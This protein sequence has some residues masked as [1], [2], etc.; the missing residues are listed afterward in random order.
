M[1][2]TQLIY[3]SRHR[4]LDGRSAL[5]TLRA[6]LAASQ[7]NNKRDELTGFLLFDQGWFYQILEGDHDQVISTYNRI[8]KDP[9]HENIR[10]MDR[11][12]L[13]RR[14]FPQWSMGGALRGPE[15][16][17]IFLRHGIADGIDPGK[18]AGATILA[19]ALDLQDYE[20][21]RREARKRQLT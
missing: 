2:V 1:A 17:E 16:Q 5:E 6:I 11:R 18:V 12:Q 15:Q 4:S 20:I 9:R 21:S 10:L 19:L 7:Q 3:S 14:S 13:P 8:Q